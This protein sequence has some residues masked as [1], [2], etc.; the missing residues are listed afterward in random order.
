MCI[1]DSHLAIHKLENTHIEI[2]N[3]YKI[4]INS[5]TTRKTILLCFC[6]LLISNL[7]LNAQT[8][9]NC[10]TEV[11]CQLDSADFFGLVFSNEE[12]ASLFGENKPTIDIAGFEAGFFIANGTQ[13]IYLTSGLSC[14]DLT[15]TSDELLAEVIEATGCTP[16]PPPPPCACPVMVECFVE[17]GTAGLIVEFASETDLFAFNSKTSG[18]IELDGTTFESQGIEETSIFYSGF[19]GSTCPDFTSDESIADLMMS[20]GCILPPPCEPNACLLYTSPS[21]R[22]Q[23][24]SR[25][26]S[27][28]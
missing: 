16:P 14:A 26:P 12:D 20:T 6:F 25:M 24:G 8:E 13:L 1:R 3:S 7:E 2:M 4:R 27:S 17:L 28:A 19:S 11:T 21:P 9:C 10:P 23:R 22:D 15:A 5:L 18:V